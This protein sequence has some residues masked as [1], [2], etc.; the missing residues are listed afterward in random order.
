MTAHNPG[1]PQTQQTTDSLA[2]SL[3]AFVTEATAKSR[4]PSNWNP[5]RASKYTLV[6]DTE[7]ARAWPLACERVR[8]RARPRSRRGRYS[9]L[10]SRSRIIALRF[11]PGPVGG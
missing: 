8:P 2:I 11:R 10:K 7:T 6:F 9:A 3:R 1:P 5:P 4:G